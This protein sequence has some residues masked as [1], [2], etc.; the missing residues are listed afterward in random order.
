MYNFNVPSTFKA[1]IDQIVRAGKTF[2]VGPTGYEG[3]VKGKKALF[4]TSSGGS[5]RARQR[6]GGATISRSR[7]CARSSASW[8]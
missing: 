6:D 3:L 4:I 1:Y 7:T 5:L 8:G 2:G